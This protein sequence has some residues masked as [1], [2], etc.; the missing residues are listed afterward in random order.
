MLEQIARH[1]GIDLIQAE[2]DLHIDEHHTI[3]DVAITLGE[4][5]SLALGDNAGIERYGFCLPMDDCLGSGCDRLW[6]AE[7]DRLGCRIQ[8]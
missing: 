2:G 3:E 7:L 1:G 4:A 6:R 5:F 8:T